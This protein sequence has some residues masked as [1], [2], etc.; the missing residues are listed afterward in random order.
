MI[1]AAFF[2]PRKG[3]GLAEGNQVQLSELPG[4]QA[5]YLGAGS[6]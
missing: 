4:K 3:I 5:G 6:A 1:H 2:K